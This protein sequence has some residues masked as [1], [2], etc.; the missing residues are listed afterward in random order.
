YTAAHLE[1][2]Q[3]AL[4]TRYRALGYNRVGIDYQ[5]GISSDTTDVDIVVRVDEGPQQR[6]RAVNTQGLTRTTPALLSH[7]LNLDIGEPVALAAWNAARC[8]AY[9]TGAFRSVDIQREVL[10]SAEAPPVATDPV[11]EPVRAIVTVQE[12]APLRFRYGIEVRD[13]LDAAGD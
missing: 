12:W 1:A 2:A 10:E 8:R 13:E 9:E 11:E 3:A 5:A 6:L 7:A 4:D